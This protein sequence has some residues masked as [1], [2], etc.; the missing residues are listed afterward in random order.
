MALSVAR[1]ETWFVSA[2]SSR[3]KQLFYRC[4][5]VGGI[6]SLK[7]HLPALKVG[8]T[9]M[10]VLKKQFFVNRLCPKFDFL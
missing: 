8:K 4:F 3:Y 10:K 2:D 9:D 1:V 7:P 5:T 6:R